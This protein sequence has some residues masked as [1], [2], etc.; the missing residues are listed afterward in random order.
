M[1]VCVST[2]SGPWQS[3]LHRFYKLHPCGCSRALSVYFVLMIKLNVSE[4]YFAKPVAIVQDDID[5]NGI[6][7]EKFRDRVY[8]SQTVSL[9][10]MRSLFFRVHDSEAITV[11]VYLTRCDDAST[12]WDLTR[13]VHYPSVESTGRVCRRVIVRNINVLL[14]CQKLCLIIPNMRSLIA[15]E[16][17]QSGLSSTCSVDLSWICFVGMAWEQ[18]VDFFCGKYN[19]L[20]YQNHVLELAVIFVMCIVWCFHCVSRLE[21]WSSYQWFGQCLH[22]VTI[23]ATTIMLNLAWEIFYSFAFLYFVLCR[24]FQQF[25]ALSGSKRYI[26]Q[27]L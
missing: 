15:N 27:S 6:D 23:R 10:L 5:V 19:F 7:S 20:R 1:C 16:A 11:Q 8:G 13:R 18:N 12:R 22:Q 24:S 21:H 9:V 26:V 25:R 2:V 4:R 17:D 3:S 14:M